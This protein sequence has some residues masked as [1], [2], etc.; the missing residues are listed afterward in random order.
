MLT[1]QRKQR[2]LALSWYL[3]LPGKGFGRPLPSAHTQ[4]GSPPCRGSQSGSAPWT[5][6]AQTPGGWGSASSCWSQL[7][8]AGLRAAALWSAPH[9]EL[10]YLAVTEWSQAFHFHISV[11]ESETEWTW[12]TVTES[13]ISVPDPSYRVK[14]TESSR[15]EGIHEI[16]ESNHHPSTTTITP[17]PHPRVPCPD[18]SWTLPELVIPQLSGQLIPVP[19]HSCS[20]VFV[21]SNKFEPPLA[22]LKAISFCPFTESRTPPDSNLLSG[23][24]SEVGEGRELFSLFLL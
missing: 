20:Q 17:K 23:G 13:S 2:Q 24:C 4:P 6:R 5:G 14:N 1:P 22:H 15:L 9:N 12:L 21:Y 16:T 8:S 10:S 19:N 3:Q 18:T 11:T 7:A